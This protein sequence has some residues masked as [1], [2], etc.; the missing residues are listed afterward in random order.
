MP[1]EVAASVNGKS[2]RTGETT[3]DLL[4]VL[5]VPAVKDR[6]TPKV[7]KGAGDEVVIVPHTAD[8]WGRVEAWQ[9]RGECVHSDANAS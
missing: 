5:K 8:R 4:P 7:M 6:N 2:F 9:D 1:P 3:P